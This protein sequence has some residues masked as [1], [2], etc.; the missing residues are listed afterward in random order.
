MSLKDYRQQ[1]HDRGQNM[2]HFIDFLSRGEASLLPYGSRD[3]YITQLVLIQ[4]TGP[5]LIPLL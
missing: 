4:K 3:I 5:L 2:I 1:R